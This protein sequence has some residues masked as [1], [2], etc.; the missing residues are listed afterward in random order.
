MATFSLSLTATQIQRVQ[1]AADIFNTQNGTS[2][3]AKQFAKFVCLKGTVVGYLAA[4]AVD[5]ARA[6]SLEELEGEWT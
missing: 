3:T 1:D 6:S 4:A 5:A 2:L